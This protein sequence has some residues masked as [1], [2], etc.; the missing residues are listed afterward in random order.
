MPPGPATAPLGMCHISVMGIHGILQRGVRSQ[1]PSGL[2]FASSSR[3][4]KVALVRAKVDV[5][6]SPAGKFDT[7]Y[8]SKPSTK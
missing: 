8:Y 4:G 3:Y 5:C 1:A 6:G 2:K 7:Q